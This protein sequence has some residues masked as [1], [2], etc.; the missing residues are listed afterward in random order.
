VKI[1]PNLTAQKLQEI[2]HRTRKIILEIHS[3]C[4]KNNTEIT[5]IY[6]SFVQERTVKT[7]EN[8]IKNLQAKQR[9]LV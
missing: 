5:N 2:M 4:L 3:L 9:E 7:L 1:N 6:H 8:Q